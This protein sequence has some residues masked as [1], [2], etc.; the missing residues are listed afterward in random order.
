MATI[1]PEVTGRK[2]RSRQKA[3]RLVYTVPE[4]GRLLG[5]GR[6]AAYAAAQRGDIPTL[7]IGRL[8]LVPK[9]ALHRMLGMTGAGPATPTETTDA[10]AELPTAGVKG[11]DA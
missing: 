9:I 3:E 1:K 6:N 10:G 11:E 2:P 8:L 7:R 4:A 5:L